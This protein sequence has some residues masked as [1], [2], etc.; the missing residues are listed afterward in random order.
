MGFIK[1]WRKLDKMTLETK[2]QEVI[3]DNINGYKSK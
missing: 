3:C 1:R 2:S